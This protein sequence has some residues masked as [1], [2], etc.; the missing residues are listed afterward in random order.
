M[1]QMDVIDKLQNAKQ[2]QA[3]VNQNKKLQEDKIC[4]YHD[5]LTYRILVIVKD[6]PFLWGRLMFQLLYSKVQKRK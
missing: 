5:G 1:L 4:K 6:C 2:V 3:K